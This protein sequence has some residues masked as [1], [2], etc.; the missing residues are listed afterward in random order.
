MSSVLH[1]PALDGGYYLRPPA[2]SAE[3][4]IAP[5]ERI[6]LSMP[7]VER[8][9]A[10][11]SDEGRRQATEDLAAAHEQA[12]LAAGALLALA[13]SLQ[14]EHRRVLE[15]AGEEIVS[16]A[17]RIAE[18]IL[19]R[20]VEQDPSAV[21]PLVRELLQRSATHGSL[22]VRLSPPDYACLKANLDSVP[23][24]AEVEGVRLRPDPSVS[25]GGCAVETEAGRLDG[26]L[27]TQLE[28]IAEVLFPNGEAAA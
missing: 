24:A 17:Y 6:V 11:A 8:M 12:Q 5:A 19:R 28:R 25:P 1:R 14:K 26:L 2:L 20:A 13:G 16:L 21:I 10:E 15:D 18:K 4:R 27:E 23:E 7:D 9:R 22:T 3:M